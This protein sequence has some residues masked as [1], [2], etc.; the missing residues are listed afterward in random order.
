MVNSEVKRNMRLCASAQ[1]RAFVALYE[2][3]KT[4]IGMQ[5]P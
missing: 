3:E 4:V 5:E 2:R 1:K